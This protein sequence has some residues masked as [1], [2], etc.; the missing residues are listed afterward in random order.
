MP[1][2]LGE[3]APDETP[4]FQEVLQGGT[5]VRLQK[6]EKDNPSISIPSERWLTIPGVLV[7]GSKKWPVPF[8]QL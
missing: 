1:V 4:V 6:E 7:V 5:W 8:D 3:V 2:S